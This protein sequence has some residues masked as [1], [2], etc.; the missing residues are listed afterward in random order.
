MSSLNQ[1]TCPHCTLSNSL[2]NTKCQACDKPRLRNTTDWA[3]RHCSLV[4]PSHLNRCNACEN[5]R[6]ENQQPD[7]KAVAKQSPLIAIAKF[8]GFGSDTSAKEW[9]CSKCTLTNPS[10][11]AKCAVCGHQKPEVITIDD[12]QTDSPST[13]NDSQGR[14]RLYPNLEL[15]LPAIDCH[16]DIAQ[17]SPEIVLKCPKC[18]TLLYD[19]ASTLCTVCG[20]RCD[21]EGFKPRPFPSSSVTTSPES[22]PP[23]LPGQWNCPGCT[24]ANDNSRTICEIC[25]TER[26][27]DSESQS[28]SNIVARGPS[29]VDI[30]P[31]PSTSGLQTLPEGKIFMVERGEQ[32]G[33][34]YYGIGPNLLQY[35]GKI[36]FLV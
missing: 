21:S 26:N 1:W 11:Q 23:A 9:T 18:Q 20:C 33:L 27:M 19:N 2:E 24:F 30:N 17:Q 28:N 15:E 32:T 22:S 6:E 29:S 34:W 5:L 3:C 8:F 31:I 13:T 10:S 16:S 7:N 4:N 14:T 25:N 12:E 36:I 35:F